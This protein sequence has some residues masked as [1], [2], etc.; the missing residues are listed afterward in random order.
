M[1]PDLRCLFCFDGYLQRCDAKRPCSLCIENGR[2]EECVY[3]QGPVRRVARK[4]KPTGT[5]RSPPLYKSGL[6]LSSLSRW[7]S[8]DLSLFIHSLTPSDT[9]SSASSF[10]SSTLSRVSSRELDNPDE[11][12][13]HIPG[14]GSM[15][16]VVLFR[17]AASKPCD[18]TFATASSFSIHPFVRPPSIPRGLRIPLSFIDPELLRV[19][20]ATPSEMNLSLYVFSLSRHSHTLCILKVIHTAV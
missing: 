9:S 6:N 3:G 17:E 2:S 1:T 14:D 13:N 18:R 8:E 15:S 16:E 4:S 5:F 19:S 12:G 20:D 11:F 7:T 10:T